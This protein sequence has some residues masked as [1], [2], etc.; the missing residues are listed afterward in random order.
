MAI[1]YESLGFRVE[2]EPFSIGKFPDSAP[3]MDGYVVGAFRVEPVAIDELIL[4]WHSKDPWLVI[5]MLR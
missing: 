3:S 4:R 5:A 1:Q 2:S